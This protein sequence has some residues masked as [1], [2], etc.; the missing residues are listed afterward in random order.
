VEDVHVVIERRSV[1]EIRGVHEEFLKYSYD[2]V[3]RYYDSAFAHLDEAEDRTGAGASRC[4]SSSRG[5]CVTET[6]T[7]EG[8]EARTKAEGP[9]GQR[10]ALPNAEAKAWSHVPDLLDLDL[11]PDAWGGLPDLL[12][13][14]TEPNV[15]GGLHMSKFDPRTRNQND[16]FAQAQAA[17]SEE[18]E[19]WIRAHRVTPLSD[20]AGKPAKEA[21]TAEF[22]VLIMRDAAKLPLSMENSESDDCQLMVIQCATSGKIATAL[23]HGEKRLTR[24]CGEAWRDVIPLLQPTGT[25]W[26]IEEGCRFRVFGVGKGG[27]LGSAWRPHLELQQQGHLVQDH[28][29]AEGGHRTMWRGG[30]HHLPGAWRGLVARSCK[31]LR[32]H[33]EHHRDRDRPPGTG[34]DPRRAVAKQQTGAYAPQLHAH[35]E[36][37][38][39]G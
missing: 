15:E 38:V 31:T 8:P 11:E 16:P 9:G 5:T 21:F 24:D 10:G 14:E 39:Q 37:L 3:R 29:A 2:T 30:G 13:L 4:W 35:C 34:L 12:D 26:S 17:W 19:A 1:V 7:N 22:K 27:P 23:V 25:L 36:G 28:P 18:P 6:V 20:L 33:Q 32:D